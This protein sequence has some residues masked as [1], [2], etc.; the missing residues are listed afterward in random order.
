MTSNFRRHKTFKKFRRHKKVSGGKL[1]QKFFALR[2][3]YVLLN[4]STPASV[5][6]QSTG[7]YF[8]EALILAS[9]NPQH[10]K[11][12]F[13]ELQVQYMRIASSEHVVY[14]N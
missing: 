2:A 4:F 5:E 12:L 11:R 13:I 7:R 1:L 3:Y 14:I 6:I 10:D 8:S 9:T